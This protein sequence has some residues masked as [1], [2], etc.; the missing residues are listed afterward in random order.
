MIKQSLSSSS[1]D[2]DNNISLSSSGTKVLTQVED[3]ENVDPS[4]LN[5]LKLELCQPLPQFSA[6]FSSTE[7]PSWLYVNP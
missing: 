4:D 1:K 6:E 2:T 3:S 5:Q 7:A